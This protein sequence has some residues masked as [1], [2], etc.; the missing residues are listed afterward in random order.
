MNQAEIETALK[1]A[2]FECEKAFCPLNDRQKEIILQTLLAPFS[3]PCDLLENPLDQLTSEQRQALLTFI[4]SQQEQNLSWKI[5]LLNDWLNNQDSG[6]V[7]F[8]RDEYGMVWINQIQPVHL[9]KFLA[10]ERQKRLQI[11]DRLEVCNGL[12]EWVQE[13]GPCFPEWFPC[14]VVGLSQVDDGESTYTSCVVR[15]ETG[16][17]FEIQGVYEWNQSY[18]RFAPS[19]S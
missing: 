3:R 4:Q 12:W 15:F 13:E 14:V 8:I 6:A 10:Q 19:V 16:T 5:T 11:G 17:E 2:F 1:T 9:E 18:W 7:Q